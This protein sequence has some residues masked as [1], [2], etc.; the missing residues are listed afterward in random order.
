MGNEKRVGDYVTLQRG[1]T[2]KGNL[3]GQ[4]GPALL[5]LGS[6][7]PGGG[8]RELDF[9]TYGGNCPENILL[10]PGDIFASLKGATKDG[11]MIGS[12]ARVPESVPL[13]RLTQDTVKLQ[14]KTE[15][16]DSANFLYWV[17]RTPQ[18]RNYCARH[19]TGSAVVALSRDDFLNYPIP[20]NSP[21]RRD[22][23]S[24][25]EK[26]EEKIRLNYQTNATLE[27][28]AQALFKSW[29]VDFDPVID[30]ALAAGNP[31]P[32]PFQAR[33]K[34]RKA[35]GDKR[36]PLPEAIQLRFPN[37]FVLTEE[38]GW[39]PEGWC[40]KN[41]GEKF[42][43]TKGKNITKETITPGIVPVVAGGLTP[44][45]YHN[46]HNVIAPVI[47]ISASGANA[48]YVNLYHENIWASDCSFISKKHTN[49][50]Y[51]EYLF[52]KSRQYEITRMQ[53]GAAQPHVYPKDLMRL[54]LPDAPNDICEHLEIMISPFFEKSKYSLQEIGILS[55]LRDTFLPK[56]LSGQLRIPDAEQLIADAL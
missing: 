54:V 27:S 4:P 6:I 13:G 45:Y 30:N 15:C 25:L 2:Y 43:P 3:V 36:K 52:L 33:A 34:T 46:E 23:V 31:I 48:G 19:A 20:Q 7:T 53:Q 44:A 35:L 8:F 37:R 51:T 24:L 40:I 18:Y 29:F 42:V 17:L 10:R 21:T 56:L 26:I 5:G 22:I 39:I 16:K 49:H 9:K 11:E 38:M 32:E 41:F 47:T 12:V 55:N 50:I 28:M 14:F 1:I